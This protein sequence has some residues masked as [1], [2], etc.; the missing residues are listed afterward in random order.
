[1][2]VPALDGTWLDRAR[3][4]LDIIASL[5][6][7][8]DSYGAD[9]PDPLMVEA[10]WKLLKE[11]HRAL[12]APVPFLYPTRSGGVQLEW[13]SGTRY[14][15]VEVL[16]PN[17]LAYFYSDP[18]IQAESTGTI[19]LEHATQELRLLIARVRK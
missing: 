7:G 11:L 14:L 10:A 2:S 1:M 5:E 15:E 13:E 4:Q 12:H 18:S 9:P 8:W 16:S 6:R 17:D 3:D 19:L